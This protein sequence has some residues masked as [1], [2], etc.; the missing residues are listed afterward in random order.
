MHEL[1]VRVC[2]SCVAVVAGA[3]TALG[4]GVNEVRHGVS[5]A[6]KSVQSSLSSFASVA[7]SWLGDGWLGKSSDSD[8]KTSQTT[9]SRRQPWTSLSSQAPPEGTQPTL[10]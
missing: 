6:A 3:A 7:S 4:E 2:V 9:R 5:N 1:S 10:E 8:D